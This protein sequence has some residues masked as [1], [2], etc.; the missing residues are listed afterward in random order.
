MTKEHADAIRKYLEVARDLHDQRVYRLIIESCYMQDDAFE[1][2]LKGIKS[3]SIIESHSGS[4]K[5]QY[6]QTIIY[7]NNHFGEK[8]L[9]TLC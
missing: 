9:E 2:I 4:I 7:S 6:L 1:M 3:Q 8:S 5:S